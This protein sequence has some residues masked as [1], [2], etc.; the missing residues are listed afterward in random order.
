[1]KHLFTILFSATLICSNATAA[2]YTTTPADSSQAKFES[3]AKLE[4]I[5]GYTYD[6]N[7]RINC[8][9]DNLEKGVDG[10]V[11]VDLRTLKTGIEKRDE[12]MRDQYL[13][14]ESYPFARFAVTGISGMPNSLL[15]DS[16]YS[17]TVN[18][19]M[20]LHGRLRDIAASATVTRRS[21]SVN[22]LLITAQFR[23]ALAD[24]D[25][26]HPQAVFL[27]L[28]KQLEI[29]LTLNLKEK[30]RPVTKR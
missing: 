14:T 17:C 27:K 24:Y 29:E 16:A 12:H 7:A 18:G 4:F 6:I 22:N 25:I 3:T 19:Q 9:P 8:N 2:V 15:T 26:P 10:F 23:I 30:P 28:A 21:G 20:T 5:D 13:H 1:M 11:V